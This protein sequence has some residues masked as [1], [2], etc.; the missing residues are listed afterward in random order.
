M[1]NDYTV[2]KHGNIVELLPGLELILH[3]AKFQ[4]DDTTPIDGII[5]LDGF[6]AQPR[7]MRMRVGLDGKTL[8]DYNIERRIYIIAN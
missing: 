4:Q 8:F 6:T 2:L 3:S 7:S 5:V 1:M